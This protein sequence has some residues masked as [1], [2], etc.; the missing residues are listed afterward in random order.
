MTRITHA[1][2][3]ACR[4]RAA[5]TKLALAFALLASASALGCVGPLQEA[6][7]VH[8]WPRHPSG[9]GLGQAT[10]VDV[11]LHGHVFVFHR[12]HRDFDYPPPPGLIAED[13]VMMFDPDSGQQLA[14]WGADRFS[15]PHG[16]DVDDQGNVWVT[17]VGLHQV[18]KFSHDGE[19]L[20][21][22]GVAGEPGD[23]REHL[24]LPTDVVVLPD[25]SF[26]VADG[27]ENSR[28]VR[29][30][31]TGEFVATW[32]TRGSGPG[33]FAVPHGIAWDGD[34]LLYVADRGNRRVQAFGLD[35][36]FE[37][38]WVADELGR[39]YGIDVAPS[40]ELVVIDGGDLP[41]TGP[42]RSR[43]VILS[44]EGEIRATLGAFGSQDGQ[45]RLGHDVAVGDD[46]TIYVVDAWGRRVQKFVGATFH[47]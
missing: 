27:Y 41:A 7:V 24:G 42:D 11:D 8:G 1:I 6:T 37:F 12:A 3:A 17:D 4:P 22:W 33:Q 15:I 40:G 13:T 2:A 35:G 43:V 23:D 25:G 36:T 34:A 10:G 5:T 28:V 20:Q 29:F 39:P 32:G 21:T 26:Y 46:G 30:S 14:A 19:L 31:P 47:E 45:F 44:P 16:L 38:A 9:H 18:L